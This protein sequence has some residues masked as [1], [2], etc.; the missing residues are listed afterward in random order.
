[1]ER[2]E[3]QQRPHVGLLFLIVLTVVLSGLSG[4]GATAG[5]SP[6]EFTPS[7]VPGGSEV[8]RSG[9]LSA[10]GWNYFGVLGN[11]T[12]TDAST[13]GAVSAATNWSQVASGV[14]TTCGVRADGTMWCWGAGIGLGVGDGT[15]LA[16]LVPQEVGNDPALPAGDGNTWTTVTTGGY[17]SCAIRQDLTLWCWGQGGNGVLG[18]G[19]SIDRLAPTEVGTA[20]DWREVSGGW[21]HTCAVRLGGTLWCWGNNSLGQLGNGTLQNSDSPVQIGAAVPPWWHVSVGLQHSCATR[22]DFTLWCWGRNDFGQLGDGTNIDRS[23]PVQVGVGTN[24][25]SVDAGNLHTCAQ[26]ID[27]TLWCWGYN[28]AGELGDGTSTSRS[29]PTQVGALADWTQ[30]SAG[31]EHTCALRANRTLWCWGANWHGAFGNGATN[32]VSLVPQQVGTSSSY[33]AVGA[34]ENNTFAIQTPSVACFTNME[35]VLGLWNSNGNL[36]AQFGPALSGSVGFGQGLADQG[37]ALNGATTLS[38]PTLPT[39]TNAVTVEMWVKPAANPQRTQ[40]LATRWDFPSTD[41]SARSY[42]LLLDPSSRLHWSTDDVSSR[43][44]DE[45]VAEAPTIFD[46][47]FHH[48]VATWDQRR[49][50]IYVDGFAIASAPSQG[51]TLNPATSTPFRLGSES[52]LGTPFFFNGIIDEATIWG[53][54]LSAREVQDIQSER[55]T[56][57]ATSSTTQVT[58]FGVVAQSSTTAQ[59]DAVFAASPSNGPYDC[60]YSVDGASVYGFYHGCVSP[61]TYTPTVSTGVHTFGFRLCDRFGRC[62]TPTPVSINVV[63]PAPTI[64]TFSASPIQPATVQLGASMNWTTDS[65]PVTCRFFADGV[66]Q[67]AITCGTTVSTSFGVSPGSHSLTMSACDRFNQCANAGPQTLTWPSVTISWDTGAV[68]ASPYVITTINNFPANASVTLQCH[69]NSAFAFPTFTT[70]TN[71][72]NYTYRHASAQA[73]CF[74]QRG[75]DTWVTATVNGITYTSNHIS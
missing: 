60:E 54:A 44:P 30:L 75:I 26:R 35:G 8:Q 70:S 62:T 50:A 20:T 34:G 61:A 42:E 38:A 36:T 57:C 15:N 16:R 45:L 18:N 27:G 71:S 46:G 6:P 10:T 12:T 19:T 5:F 4:S 9:T 29:S 67:Q 13:P 28:D 7:S 31:A 23:A 2:S 11:G 1:V 72:G 43:R 55:N 40:A 53:R 37:L 32:S 48:I 56:K 24:W 64:S 41:D 21:T 49:S 63:P 33:L 52:G 51:G 58:S 17:H 3:H 25:V 22:F 68:G 47:G 73:V 14:D 59:M 69:E 65:N 66:L 39:V 74:Q